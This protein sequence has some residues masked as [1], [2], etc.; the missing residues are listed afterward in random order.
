MVW[1]EE[2]VFSLLL[3]AETSLTNSEIAQKLTEEFKE[4]FS[5]NCVIGKLYRLDKTVENNRER[6]NFK[7]LCRVKAEAMS[8]CDFTD[9]DP[10]TMDDNFWEVNRWFH[11]MVCDLIPEANI[12]PIWDNTEQGV[13]KRKM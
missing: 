13:L 12:K 4:P 3:L 9:P 2:K 7:N 6:A 11:K 10:E 5:R 8:A 1:T